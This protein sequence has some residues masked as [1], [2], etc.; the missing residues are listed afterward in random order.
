MNQRM[1]TIT[2]GTDDLKGMTDFYV[3]KLGW[4]PVGGNDDVLLFRLNGFLLS[5]LPR[6][7]LANY[8]GVEPHEGGGVF[9][10]GYNVHSKEEVTR[11]YKTLKADGV[12][13][14]RDPVEGDSDSCFFYFADID[15]NI[16]E[17]A[18]NPYVA[19][20]EDDN[21]VNHGYE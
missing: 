9:T 5:I 13:I 14:V 3:K 7:L 21:L 8:I 4:K 2:I 12:T 18:Y 17:V 19:L 10:F 6:R 15:G 20:D 16:F 11:V 1:H